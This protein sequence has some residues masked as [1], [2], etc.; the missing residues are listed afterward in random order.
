MLKNTNEFLARVSAAEGFARQNRYDVYI[1]APLL[2]QNSAA[3]FQ[4]IEAKKPGVTGDWM[5]YPDVDLG[6]MA[7]E[8]TTFCDKSELPGY[9]FQLETARHYGPSFKIPHMPEYQDITMTFMCGNEMWER[10]FF[11]A[12]M[13]MIMDPYTNDFNYKNEYAVG[14]DLV[15]Y[16]ERATSVNLNLDTAGQIL[17][18]DFGLVLNPRIKVSPFVG[19]T[20]F[21]T[22]NDYVV[23][24]NYF[25][26]LID[27][28]PISIGPQE[29]GYDTNNSIQKI[30]VTF[31]YKYAVP[32]N[33]KGSS[34]GAKARGDRQYFEQSVT[35]KPPKPPADNGKTT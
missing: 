14:I 4:A 1:P 35:S 11:E 12:W 26:T 32:F 15:Q 9:Q 31:S 22:A 20:N 6:A 33:A 2:G 13:Y 21:E 25:T 5:K 28:F 34:T 27:A 3:I 24:Y 30:Q 17:N 19:K 10:Y 8:L 29:L 16:K 23:D 18:T 7:L